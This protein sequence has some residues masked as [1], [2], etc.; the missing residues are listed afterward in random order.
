MCAGWPAGTPPTRVLAREPVTEGLRGVRD[1]GAR[2]EAP[3]GRGSRRDTG[4]DPVRSAAAVLR[5]R[6]RTVDAP[7]GAAAG[8]GGLDAG[9]G[10]HHA[11]GGAAACAGRLPEALKRGLASLDEQPVAGAGVRPACCSCAPRRSRPAEA[12]GALAR[13]ARWMLSICTTWCRAASSRCAPSR[14][15]NW[16][17]WH[18]STAAAASTS[19]RRNWSGAPPRATCAATLATWLGR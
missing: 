12:G 3:A 1:G 5:P 18:C 11:G 7:A 9:C 16:W 4:V 15:R 13:I 6:A 19:L 14:W 17:R 8:A 10:V 2:T